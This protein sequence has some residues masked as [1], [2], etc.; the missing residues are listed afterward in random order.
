MKKITLSILSVLT[1]FL[2]NAQDPEYNY[3]VEQISVAGSTETYEIKLTASAATMGPHEITNFSTNIGW[4]AGA[5]DTP[6]LVNTGTAFG[7]FGTYEF[8]GVGV[9]TADL[10]NSIQAMPV[11]D[12]DVLNISY[13]AFIPDDHPVGNFQMVRFSVNRTAMGMGAPNPGIID[14]ADPNVTKIN[15]LGAGTFENRIFTDIDGPGPAPENDRFNSSLPTLSE[16]DFNFSALE[17]T[18]YPNP[19]KGALKVYNPS[20]LDFDYEIVN[21]E[22]RVVQSRS[23]LYSRRENTLDLSAYNNG[24]YFLNIKSGDREQQTIKIIKN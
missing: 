17:F 6:V 5:F 4:D 21:L 19:T 24:V 20:D 23:T 11:S 13:P 8:P 7:D 9:L 14:N 1:V 18:S 10:V 16:R 3:S 12:K 22:G 2:G 15:G